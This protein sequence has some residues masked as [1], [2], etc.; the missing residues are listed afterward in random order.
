MIRYL[1]T[2][3][4]GPTL[5][6]AIDGVGWTSAIVDIHQI[7]V[8]PLVVLTEVTLENSKL[9]LSYRMRHE[10]TSKYIFFT[11]FVWAWHLLKFTKSRIEIIINPRREVL[12]DHP[13]LAHPVT[14]LTDSLHADI[15]AVHLYTPHLT[16]DS[17]VQHGREVGSLAQGAPYWAGHVAQLD[18][19]EA[20]LTDVVPTAAQ[21]SRIE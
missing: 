17:F 13:Y 2:H 20:W 9:A 21:Q 10:I 14:S 12:L 16:S 15:G 3:N 19:L 8:S 6:G 1:K 18:L 7:S 4:L 11:A 5:V